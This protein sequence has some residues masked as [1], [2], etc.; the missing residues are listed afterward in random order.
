MAAPATCPVALRA[1]IRRCRF[2]HL[3]FLGDCWRQ[4]G[5]RTVDAQPAVR[6]CIGL[7]VHREFAQVAVWQ[8]GAVTQAGRIA[9]TAQQLRAFAETLG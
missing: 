6:R 1:R 4:E 5:L 3:H 7:D 8:A 9:T 2:A